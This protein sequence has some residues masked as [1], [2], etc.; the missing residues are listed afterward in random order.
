MQVHVHRVEVE[1][2]VL[3]LRERRLMVNGGRDGA[4]RL[5]Y[6]TS[7][8]SLPGPYNY[9]ALTANATAPSASS[10]T[11]TAE[12]ATAGGGLIRAQAAYAHTNG[13]STAT[14]T[15][16]FTA[17]GTDSLPV[18]VAKMGGFDASTAGNMGHETLLNA[19][20]TLTV[21]GDNVTVT[22]TVTITPS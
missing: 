9:I 21:S 5:L 18:T 8:S 12:I 22:Q 4:F 2:L 13:T 11:L 3:E 10:T 20:A 19:T 16:T 17:N 7:R 6:D 1:A 15:K 14:L